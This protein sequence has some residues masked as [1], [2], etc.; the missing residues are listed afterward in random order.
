MLRLLAVAVL[1]AALVAC[2]PPSSH[3]ETPADET[4]SPL[5]VE[6]VWTGEVVEDDVR[7]EIVLTLDRLVPG[8]AA[9]TTAYT[10]GLTCSGTLTFEGTDRRV[11]SF[12]E[13]LDG[14]PACADSGRVD[15]RLR[16]DG[17]LGWL[18]YRTDGDAVPDARATLDPR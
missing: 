1:C 3:E 14:S 17:R 8:A 15:V 16:S 6:G 2:G 4:P 12:R 5:A 10:G 9:G 18:W 11:L 13:A 7:Y